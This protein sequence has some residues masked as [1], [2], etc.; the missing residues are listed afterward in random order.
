MAQTPKTMFANGFRL[1]AGEALKHESF[2]PPLNFNRNT[3]D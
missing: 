3:N 1:R 2:N